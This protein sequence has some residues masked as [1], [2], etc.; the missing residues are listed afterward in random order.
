M[1]DW[2][3]LSHVRGR[4]KERNKEF[5]FVGQSMAKMALCVNNHA[6]TGCCMALLAGIHRQRGLGPKN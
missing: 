3:S 4:D 1:R 2:K 5:S 6:D